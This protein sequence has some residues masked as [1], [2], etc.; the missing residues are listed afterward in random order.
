L[1]LRTESEWGQQEGESKAQL[2]DVTSIQAPRMAFHVLQDV[3]ALLLK[4]AEG[5]IL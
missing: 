1:L 4:E 5:T 2:G 3:P